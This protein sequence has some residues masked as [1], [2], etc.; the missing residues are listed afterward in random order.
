M[1]DFKILDYQNELSLY[2]I[3][4]KV[5]YKRC[6]CD[7]Y[8]IRDYYSQIGAYFISKGLGHLDI[9]NPGNNV[10]VS[11]GIYVTCDYFNE[12]ILRKLFG[13]PLYHDEFGEGFEGEYDEELED[14]LEP[15]NESSYASY[16]I[17]INNIVLYIGYDH[18]GTSFEVKDVDD[19]VSNQQVIDAIKMLIDISIDSE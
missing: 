11:A 7:L 5:T 19:S 10:N 13:E 4:D 16:F 3:K 17:E 6:D 9:Y 18:R 14:Y 15:E 2:I 12:N 8:D 1:S